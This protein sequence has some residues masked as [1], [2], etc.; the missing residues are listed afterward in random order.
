VV[1]IVSVALAA[2][3]LVVARTGQKQFSELVRD[4][5][6]RITCGADGWAARLRLP[7]Y[8]RADVVVDPQVAFGMPVVAQGGARIE[9]LV[10]RFPAGDTIGDIADDFGVPADQVEDVIRVATRAAA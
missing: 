6:R 10:D 4:Y 1:S 9:D 3:L 8:G 2:V 7:T 5:L